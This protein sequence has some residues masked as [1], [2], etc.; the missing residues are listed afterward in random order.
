[1]QRRRQCVCLVL[2]LLLARPW[3]AAAAPPPPPTCLAS[4][5]AQQL[6]QALPGVLQHAASRLRAALRAFPPGGAAF[7]LQTLPSGQWSRAGVNGWV[8]GFLPGCLYK[9]AELTGDASWAASAAA[10]LPVIEP[11]QHMTWVRWQPI[12]PWH[13]DAHQLALP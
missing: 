7:P 3:A 11:Q 10:M 12:L 4:A 5:D 2:A 6:E 8:A 1:M 13:A 9:M